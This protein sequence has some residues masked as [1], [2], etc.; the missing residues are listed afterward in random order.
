MKAAGQA[1]HLGVVAAGVHLLSWCGVGVLAGAAPGH[2]DGLQAGW[3]DAAWLTAL[4]FLLASAVLFL[5]VVLGVIRPRSSRS[6][7]HTAGRVAGP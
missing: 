3:T 6:A 7:G 2:A 4:V 5:G 1:G